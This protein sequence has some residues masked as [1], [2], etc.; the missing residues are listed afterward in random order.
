MSR[1]MGT[2]IGYIMLALPAMTNYWFLATVLCYAASLAGYIAFLATSN[3]GAGRGATL[4]LAL[5]LAAHYMALVDRSRGAHTVPYNDLY[6]S[7]SLFAWLLA[8]TYL[9]LH[10]PR[11]DAPTPSVCAGYPGGGAGAS[12]APGTQTK[13][14]WRQSPAPAGA[15]SQAAEL[16][17]ELPTRDT[18]AR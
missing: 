5:G 15:L 4:L 18:R 1:R 9:G 6:G 8:A 7:L 10:A 13:I 12:R 16:V 2:R 17:T 3:R 11:R 14:G